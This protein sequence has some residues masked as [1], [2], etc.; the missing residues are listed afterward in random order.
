VGFE[1][2]AWAVD[3]RLYPARVLADQPSGHRPASFSLPVETRAGG[4]CVAGK[5]A[6]LDVA[7]GG[8]RSAR[9]AYISAGR[10]VASG[11]ARRP[12]HQDIDVL[13]CIGSSELR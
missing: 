11:A 2:S 6:G 4:S 1:N 7:G 5:A 13:G 9:S 3:L 12:R 8:C 10:G